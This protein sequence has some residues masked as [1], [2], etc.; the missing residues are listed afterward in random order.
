VQAGVNDLHDELNQLTVVGPRRQLTMITHVIGRAMRGIQVT[1]VLASTLLGLAGE[2]V[3]AGI[4]IGS[5]APS[6]SGDDMPPALPKW[7]TNIPEIDY[8]VAFMDLYHP[9]KEVRESESKRKRHTGLPT[10]CAPFIYYRRTEPN[11]LTLYACHLSVPI[12]H[13]TAAH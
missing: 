6:D 8:S 3:G 11:T 1:V 4:S 13:S 7:A 5:D 12:F 9:D 2:A 10:G